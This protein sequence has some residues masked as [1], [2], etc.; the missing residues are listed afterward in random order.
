MGNIRDRVPYANKVYVS[1]TL[2]CE[3]TANILFPY[4][5]VNIMQELKE[6]DCSGIGDEKFWE[7]SEKDFAK[8]VNLTWN[9]MFNQTAKMFKTIDIDAGTDGKT[10][11]VC[12]THGMFIRYVYWFIN[13]QPKTS[14]YKVINS[15]D[16]DFKNLDVLVVDYNFRLPDEK[17]V[18]KIIRSP[19]YFIT[20]KNHSE[21]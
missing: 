6:F 17:R 1:P 15:I 8:K 10:E 11:A 12:V 13:N 4:A 19:W 18:D 3:H 14:P 16:F 7:M 20:P 9:D 21:E 2:R 5:N